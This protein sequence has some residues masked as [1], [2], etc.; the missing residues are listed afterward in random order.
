MTE[1]RTWRIELPYVKPPLSLNDRMHWRK[2]SSITS[3]LR[4]A[5]TLLLRAKRVPPLEYAVVRLEWVVP[6]R[7]RRDSDNPIATL[8]VCADALV[9][10]GVL[11]DDTPQYVSKRETDIVYEKGSARLTFIVTGTPREE[12]PSD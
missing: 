2:K 3:A 5:T 6:T 10:A 7:T 4:S 1:E 9:D 12:A 11:P 8:K